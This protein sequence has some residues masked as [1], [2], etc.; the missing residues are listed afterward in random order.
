MT[1]KN[2]IR[3]LLNLLLVIT[4]FLIASAWHN[5]NLISDKKTSPPFQL[6]TYSGLNVNLEK[7]RGKLVLLYFFAPWCKICDLNISNLNWIRKIRDKSSVSIFAVALSY[8]NIEEIESFL[9]RNTLEVPVLLGTPEIL[10]SYQISAFP[11]IYAINASGKILDST[12]GYTTI[13]GLLWRTF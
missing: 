7:M 13:L 8:N 12:V 3:L 6:S 1:F 9:E 2:W 5:R 11:T 4:I 10:N